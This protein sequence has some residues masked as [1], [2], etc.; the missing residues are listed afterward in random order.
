MKRSTIRLQIA[1]KGQPK[2]ASAFPMYRSIRKNLEHHPSY[3]AGSVVSKNSCAV[4]YAF[5][6]LCFWCSML[7]V[8]HA[9]GDLCFWCSMLLVTYASGVLCYGLFV[10]WFCSGII[11]F[12]VSM[13]WCFYALVFPCFGAMV[14][15]CFAALVFPCFGD[16]SLLDL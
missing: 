3:T 13:L 8:F 10:P 16:V 12:G 9:F 1:L 6:D 11:C 5:G 15:P 7:L 14:F 2:G 4:V